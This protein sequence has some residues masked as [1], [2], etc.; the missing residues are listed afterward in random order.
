MEMAIL[1]DL[2]KKP[3]YRRMHKDQSEKPGIWNFLKGLF[4]N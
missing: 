3:V 1:D 2:K 4:G